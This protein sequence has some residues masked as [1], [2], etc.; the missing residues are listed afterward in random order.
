MYKM[1]KEK[2]IAIIDLIKDCLKDNN[3]TTEEKIKFI[4][5]EYELLN[6]L[7]VL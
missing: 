3:F 7:I 2:L 4:D 1:Q 6:M 5:M